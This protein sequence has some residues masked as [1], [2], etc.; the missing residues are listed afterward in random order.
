MS[1]VNLKKPVPTRTPINRDSLLKSNIHHQLNDGKN[2]SI[3]SKIDLA[4]N[5]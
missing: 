2:A 5:I 3:C 4:M 1:N